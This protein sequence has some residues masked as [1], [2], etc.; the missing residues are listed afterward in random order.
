MTLSFP[1]I[2]GVFCLALVSSFALRAHAGWPPAAGAD[3]KDKANWPNDYTG[4][5]SYLSYVPDRIP[6]ALPIEPFDLK[7]GAAGMSVD[8]AWTYT[9]GR[10][11]VTIA[12]I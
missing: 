5:W 8:R 10:P 7:L 2:A 3:M 12:V 4:Q 1:R 9:T 11:D 6:G